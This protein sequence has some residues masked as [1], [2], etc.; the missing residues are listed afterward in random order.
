MVVCHSSNGN[1][2]WIKKNLL[3]EVK[4]AKIDTQSRKTEFGAQHQYNRVTCPLSIDREVRM[5]Q[6]KFILGVKKA[7][8]SL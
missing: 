8:T 4:K 7:K 1:F 3:L 2:T 5:E 6:E